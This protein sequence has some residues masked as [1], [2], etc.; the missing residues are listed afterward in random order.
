MNE[1]GAWRGGPGEARKAKGDRVDFKV[2]F[3]QGNKKVMADLYSLCG[4]GDEG[5]PVITIMLPGE[6]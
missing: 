3:D 1:T 5:E 2:L 6:D 4:P